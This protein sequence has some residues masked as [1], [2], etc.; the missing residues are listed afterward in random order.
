MA[1]EFTFDRDTQRYR[2]SS[3]T[4]K[5]Q[6]I[7]AEA[8]T[9]LTES[10]IEQ[11]KAEVQKLADRLSSGDISVSQWESLTASV[12][13]E[14]HVNSY[15]LGRGGLAQVTGKDL[16]A[17]SVLTRAQYKYLRGFTKDIQS[18]TLTEAQFRARLNLYVDAIYP[19]KEAGRQA[20]HEA[21]GFRWQRD[22]LNATES[23]EECISIAQL[24]WTAIGSTKP[25]GARSCRVNDRCVRSYRKG[26]DRPQ[27]WLMSS[28]WGWVGYSV[29]QS[30]EATLEVI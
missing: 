28:G 1:R 12:L 7:S 23:C 3:G 5:G 17:M 20:G 11:Q 9:A 10:Y 8:V 16:Q 19:S 24:G 25:I 22:T 4:G 21:E 26:D 29:K 14:M 18:G 27:D 15:L 30:V 13:K 2:V 6:F